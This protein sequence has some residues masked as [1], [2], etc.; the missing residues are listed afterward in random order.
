MGQGVDLDIWHDGAIGGR[1]R[2]IAA[3]LGLD[4]IWIGWRVAGSSRL[5]R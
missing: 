5:S 4:V 3:V 1:Q 2:N